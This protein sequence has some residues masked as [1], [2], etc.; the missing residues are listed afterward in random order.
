M[1]PLCAAL[2][3]V[4][5]LF[6][7]V[8]LSAAD[9]PTPAEIERLI[10]QLGSD[11]FKEREQASKRLEAIGAPALAQLRKAATDSDSLE[12]RTRAE[13]LVRKI[14]KPLFGQRHLL[15]G[16]KDIVWT[17]AVSPDG[18]SV[19]AAGGGDQID[20]SW[21]AGSDYAVR[22][23]DAE[24]GKERT[25][26]DKG[27]T[28]AVNSLV[29]SPDGKLVFF[30]NGETIRVWDVTAG[31]ELKR[32]EDAGSVVC[33]SLSTDGKRLLSGGWDKTV[34]LWDVATRKEIKRFEGHT[35]RV[36][37]VALSPDG[38]RAASCGDEAIVRVWDVAGGKEERTLEGHGD[39]VVRVL[40]SP[41]GKNLLSGSW[42]NTAR[43]WKAD[44]GEL[45]RVF[46]GHES[47]VEG[48]AFSPDGKQVLTGSLD[49]TLRLWEAAT[50]KEIHRFEGHTGPVAR[51]AFAPDGRYVASAGWD[52]TAR[53]WR[54]PAPR[55]MKP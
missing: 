6:L 36:W 18:K 44:G 3:G 23:W 8:P 29:W 7:A 28:G 47:R 19:V 52:K 22:L 54:V 16:Y 2:A 35:G 42:D 49:K 50:G 13:E 10:Q 30:N 46:E 34:R 39:S 40:F 55:P 17:V 51:V 38:K 26:F 4:L 32:F 5:T 33:L 12:I 43:L 25:R 9:P 27:L 24:S 15:G 37:D 14:Q 11:E 53:L 45:L 1:K 21:V 41:D 20:G 48:L 31:K